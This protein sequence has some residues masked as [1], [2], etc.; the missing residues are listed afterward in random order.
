MN[1]QP[2]TN[3]QLNCLR[4]H[5]DKVE[6]PRER[7]GLTEHIEDEEAYRKTCKFYTL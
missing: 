6:C 1:N 7:L 3:K 5:R 4:F 2:L